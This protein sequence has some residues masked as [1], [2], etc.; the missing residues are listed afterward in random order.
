MGD[1]EEGVGTQ[2][3]GSRP[4]GLWD[5][6]AREVEHEVSQGVGK[7]LGGPGQAELGLC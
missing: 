3:V 5:P 2:R 1:E 4:K 6:E 7:T